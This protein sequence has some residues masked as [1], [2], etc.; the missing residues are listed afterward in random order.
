MATRRATPRPTSPNA[1]MANILG[2]LGNLAAAPTV[3]SAGKP[4][5][6]EMPLTDDARA[7]ATRWVKARAILDPIEKR[8]EAAKAEVNE[9]A[10]G[11]MAERIFE[12]GNKPSNPIVVLVKD[13]GQVDHEF[14]WLM[15][16]KFKLRFPEVPEGVANRDHLV[17]VISDCG[18]H[19]SDAEAL[20]DNE[21]DFAPVVGFRSLTS[22][23]EGTYGEGRE[24][25]E[26]SEAEKVAGRKLAALIRW[27]GEG[28]APEALTVAEKALVLDRSPNVVVKA[29]FY[30]RIKT[31]C[32]SVD[33]VK[34]V[35][36]VIQPIVY[37]SHLKFAKNDSVQDQARRKIEA[38]AEILGV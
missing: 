24:F 9:Y 20:V 33:Q 7:E 8:V 21:L 11:V 14:S 35:F 15:T 18:L 3:R 19:P 2:E 13:D 12:A 17:G 36:R 4:S 10:I 38:A 22:L 31:Y 30:S 1:D 23:L 5:K 25:F 32:R 6:W 29:G 37:P 16:D 27:T 26:S 34:A 28:D